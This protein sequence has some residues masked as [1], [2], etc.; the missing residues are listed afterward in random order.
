MLTISNLSITHKKDFTCLIENLSFTVSPGERIALIGE[1][2]NGKST[3]LRAIAN[4]EEVSR[5]AEI[6]GSIVNTFASAY[7]PQELPSMDREKSAYAFFS[8]HPAFFDQTPKDL[9]RIASQLQLPPDVFYS[10][11]IMASFSGGERVKLQLAR[12]L[13][14][15]PQLLLLD[16]PSNDLDKETVLW[17]EEFLI[18]C[19]LAILFVSHDE[20]LLRR[21]A[22]GVVLLERLRR[23][24]LPRASVSRIG[25][26][27]FVTSRAD[28]F[29]HQEQI[30]KK[31]REEYG[32]KMERFNQIRQR[33]EHEQ[34][35]ISRRDP[36]GSRLLK[37]KMHAVMSMGRRFDREAENMTAMPEAEEAIFAKLEC[38]PLPP[39]KTILDLHLPQLTIEG[40]TL[41]RDIRLNVRAGEKICITGKNGAGKS[42]LLRHIHSLIKDRTDIRVFYMP[43]DPSDILD[44]NQTP[45]DALTQSGDKEENIRICVALGSM[46][47]T[48]DEMQHPAGMLSGGQKAKL[49]F[50]AMA[51]SGANVLLLDEPT[52]NLSPLSGPVIRSLLSDYPG[53][54]IAVSHDRMFEQEIAS[55]ICRLD[56]SGIH[57][58]DFDKI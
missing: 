27:A 40:R 25:Y 24:Q 57:D 56:E 48:A 7:L 35:V 21:A 37:K 45:V 5:Y 22:T 36:Q 38:T 29:A 11:Q 34:N 10:D 4:E 12:L 6:S 23:R 52:R 42:T 2:G 47:F 16:E 9:G 55:R 41:S 50:L 58:T 39:S 30:A 44:M 14:S 20:M 31:E 3:L 32:K 28:L 19:R 43:Q 46:K 8:E 53:C 33:V 49:M 17:L 51:M 1:E 18:S 13:L 54:I 26:D 15:S